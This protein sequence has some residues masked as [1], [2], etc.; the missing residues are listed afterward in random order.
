MKR[1]SLFSSGVG[2][3]GGDAF[4]EP[5]VAGVFDDDGSSGSEVIGPV[6]IVF[7]A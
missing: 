7:L 3:E 2:E 5:S 6:P 4:S 1:T